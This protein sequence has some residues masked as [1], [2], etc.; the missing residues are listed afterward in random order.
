VE[1]KGLRV[2][3]S[4]DLNVLDTVTVSGLDEYHKAMKLSR[5]SYAKPVQMPSEI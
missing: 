5:L 1:E 2:D 3:G 4:L